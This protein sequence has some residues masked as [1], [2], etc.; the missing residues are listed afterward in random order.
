[1]STEYL[2]YV[3]Y[4][5][6]SSRHTQNLA[7]TAWVIYT[8]MGQFFSSGGVCLWP[9]SNNIIEYSVMIELLHNAIS[10]SIRSLEVHLDS[11]LVVLQLN[12]VYCIRDPNL[13]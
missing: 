9:S 2:V 8:P 12:G 7:L 13:L 5:D 4:A 1:M 10:H 11:Q 3:G 6:G